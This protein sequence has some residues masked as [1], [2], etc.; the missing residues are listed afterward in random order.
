M[1]NATLVM[2]KTAAEAAVKETEAFGVATLKEAEVHAAAAVKELV[3]ANADRSKLG[4]ITREMIL[5]DVNLRVTE[6]E[7]QARPAEE[8]RDGL[9]TS[10]A[11]LTSD[12]AWMRQFGIAHIV[13][14]ILD[15]LENTDAV[16]DVNKRARKAGFK[17]GYNQC[18]NDVNPFFSSKFTDQRC[19]FHGVDTESAFFVV[20]D[21]Y[22]GLI[23]P[24]LDQIEA[25]FEVDD[26]VDRLCMLFAPRTEGEGTSG[27]NVE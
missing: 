21:A 11:Q 15:A 4:K 20:V 12:R 6:A 9:A 10:I 7:A 19:A 25:C 13:E 5:A 18:L 26:Y 8:D 14:S 22:N 23:I 17:V 3:D 1:A 2:E 24:A 27:G 16:A